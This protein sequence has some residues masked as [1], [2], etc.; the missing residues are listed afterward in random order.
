MPRRVGGFLASAP[1]WSAEEE[2]TRR[3]A[4]SWRAPFGS[5]NVGAFGA[6]QRAQH[7]ERD[8]Q[9]DE[10][11]D[12]KDDE[13]G[14]QSHEFESPSRNR[15]LV[16]E[17]V[18]EFL[19]FGDCQLLC[20]NGYPAETFGAAR[21]T[22]RGLQDGETIQL[23]EPLEMIET[24]N[25]RLTSPIR[26]QVGPHTHDANRPEQCDATAVAPLENGANAG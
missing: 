17:V 1:R 5:R 8:D 10:E 6:G 11:G 24:A 16:V 4:L 23:A 3:A 9:K 12:L 14:A 26:D 2:R 13:P 19:P 21:R 18:V 22:Q 20:G 15:D 25:W 7:H